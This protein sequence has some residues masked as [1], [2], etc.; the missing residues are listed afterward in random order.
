MLKQVQQCE[1]NLEICKQQIVSNA[2][3]NAAINHST[4]NEVSRLRFDVHEEL[5]F[6]KGKLLKHT[7][8]LDDYVTRI[9]V[10]E[11]ELQQLGQRVA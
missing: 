11:P 5:K 6:V 8:E 1:K 10:I 9:K 3:H 4:F 2:E 7:N